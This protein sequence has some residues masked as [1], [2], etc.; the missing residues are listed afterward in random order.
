MGR[1]ERAGT[2]ALAMLALVGCATT[3]GAGSAA[4]YG[5]GDGAS[6]EQAVVVHAPTEMAGTRA[7]Y[8]WIAARYPG[9]HRDRQALIRCNGRP[10]D[11]LRI[12]TAAGQEVEIFFDISE[13][14]G[15][16]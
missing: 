8:D 11:Q 7:E 1:I 14:F 16:F 6:C 5:A 4:A 10:A 13:Y 15:R 9:Y 2:A 12:R 3:S